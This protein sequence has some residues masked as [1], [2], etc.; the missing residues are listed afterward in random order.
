MRPD[1]LTSHP[2]NK[3]LI[4]LRDYLRYNITAF[5]ALYTNIINTLL[6]CVLSLGIHWALRWRPDPYEFPMRHRQASGIFLIRRRR[7]NWIV[8]N[9]HS[10]IMLIDFCLISIYYSL[11]YVSIHSF[12]II[13][14]NPT[15]SRFPRVRY[16]SYFRLI[17]LNKTQCRIDLALPTL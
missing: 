7:S 11:F 3:F 13:T 9:C 14:S 1:F 10:C 5:E 6:S 8:L 16:A 2:I 17:S 15:S 4:L 12:L